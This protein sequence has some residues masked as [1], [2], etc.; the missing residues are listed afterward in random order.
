MTPL[1]I[2]LRLEE[3]VGIDGRPRRLISALEVELHTFFGLPP[4]QAA[5]RAEQV[6]PAVARLIDQRSH[7]AER[8]GVVATLVLIG[9]ASDSVAGTCHVLPTDALPL[10]AVKEGRLNARDLLTAIQG[11]DYSQFE[12][13]GR[14]VLFELGA[15]DARV[16]KHAGD[17]GIDFY[18]HLSV[19]A[20]MALPTP[21]FRLAHEVRLSFAGQAKHYP[22]ST[23]GPNVVRELIG[24][25][26]L[27]RTKTF[28]AET[29]D[30]FEGSHIKPFSP[31]MPLLF[32][33]GKVSR[34]AYALSDAAG[35]VVKSG[36]QIATFLADLR[37]GIDPATSKFNSALFS[38][39]LADERLPAA[40]ER[41]V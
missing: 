11:L 6:A 21:F 17:Q 14:R 2:L 40:V 38:D 13:F 39:W 10:S 31:V 1:K 16:T 36:E 3:T 5:E 23:I 34:G 41:H 18:G 30:L 37:V 28:S 26:A 25:V 19:G 20:L 27:A 9:A 35:I 32:T 12:R 33:T 7:E 24:S 8:S 4:L 15:T 22:T 29:D